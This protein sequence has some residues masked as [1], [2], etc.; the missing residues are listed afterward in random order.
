MR[1]TPYEDPIIVMANLK[2]ERTSVRV[3]LFER[4]VEKKDFVSVACRR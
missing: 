2:K 1:I 3:V 4:F